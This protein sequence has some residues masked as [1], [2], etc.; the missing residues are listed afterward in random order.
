MSDLTPS[1]TVGPFFSFGLCT[2]P[3][4]LVVPATTAGAV[5]IRG[6]VIDGAGNG[7]PDAMVEIRQADAAGVYRGEF[8]WGRC[9]TDDDG[10]YEF[11]TVK[12]GVV[13]NVPTR[14]APHVNVLVF[15]RGLLKP[16]L[17]RMYFPDED[18]ANTAD[19][20]LGAIGDAAERSALIA[21]GDGEDLRFDIYLQGP[22]QTTFF[23]L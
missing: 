5:H 8:G 14:Q 4:H 1:Q 17:T 12:P 3:T 7:V 22:E 9:G 21:R 2:E 20:V 11:L 10:A 6:R 23:A 18:A 16:L 19:A 15:A 13:A